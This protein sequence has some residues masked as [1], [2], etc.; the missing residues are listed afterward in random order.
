[1]GRTLRELRETMDPAEL[2]IWIAR[3]RESP[4]GLDREDFHAAQVAA[5]V[6]GG[7]VI[8][9]M[10]RWGEAV[11]DDPEAALDRLMGGSG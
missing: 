1:M 4:I 6:G 3:N 9:L 8:D 5:A 7:K 2:A 11:R 10:P